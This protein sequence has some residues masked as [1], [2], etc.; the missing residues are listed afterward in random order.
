MDG[1]FINRYQKLRKKTISML[2][3]Y[4]QFIYTY[5]IAKLLLNAVKFYFLHYY[6]FRGRIYT[7]Q[8]YLSVQSNDFPL[9]YYTSKILIY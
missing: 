8:T 3:K 6:D 1:E 5:S 2:S 4:R 7:K 9:V